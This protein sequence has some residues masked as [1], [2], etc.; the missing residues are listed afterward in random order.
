MNQ[1]DMPYCETYHKFIHLSGYSDCADFSFFLIF[2]KRGN[3]R[4]T[5]WA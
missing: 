5:T 2:S 4:D 1:L 3:K